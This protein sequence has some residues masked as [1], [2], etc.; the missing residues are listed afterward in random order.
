M[1]SQIQ[2]HK[3]FKEK[4]LTWDSKGTILY[5]AILLDSHVFKSI[6]LDSVAQGL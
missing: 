6:D 2:C 4:A 3:L 5:L 1:R